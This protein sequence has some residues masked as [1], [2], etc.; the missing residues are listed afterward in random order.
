[1]T[2]EILPIIFKILVDLRWSGPYSNLDT[3]NKPSIYMELF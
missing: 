1:M 2:R 3:S